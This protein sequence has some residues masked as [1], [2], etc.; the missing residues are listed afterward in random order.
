MIRFECDYLEGALPEIMQRLNETN[1]YQTPGYGVDDFC[2]SAR[3]KIKDACKAPNADV[4]F[5]VGGTQANLTIISA[6]LRSHQGVIAASS[7]HINVHETGAIEATGSKV[8]TIPSDDGKISADAIDRMVVNH[9]SDE[10]HEHMVQPGMVYISQPTESGTVYTA[11][12]L[13]AISEVCKKHDIYLFV[14]GARLGCALVCEGDMPQLPEIAELCDVFYI[15]GTKLGA[16]FGEAVVIMNDSLK[17][18]FRYLIKQHGGMFAK[19]RLLGIQFDTLFTDNLYFKTAKREVELAIKLKNAFLAKGWKLFFD[20]PTNQ[21]YP[22][23][24]NEIIPKLAENYSF[25]TWEKFDNGTTAIRFC[26]SWAT[27]EENVDKL[28]EDIQKL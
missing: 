14:D 1:E 12:E 8:L 2:E 3:A 11:S 6:A 21:Q 20:S 28:I 22:I 24:P 27:K 23:V 15:G 7:G 25:S 18:D 17:K 26:T 13:R 5:L 4:H 19:G 10:T 9:W 16:L